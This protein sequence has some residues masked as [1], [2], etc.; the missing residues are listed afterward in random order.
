MKMSGF[1]LPTVLIILLL[2]STINPKGIRGGEFTVN[3][4]KS[5]KAIVALDIVQGHIREVAEPPKWFL[6]MRAFSWLEVGIFF[7]ISGYGLTYAFH[8]NPDFITSF[9]KRIIKVLVPFLVAHIVYI[10]GFWLF[11]IPFA[12]S[13]IVYSL[14]GKGTLVRNGWYVPICL[15][16]YLIFWLIWSAVNGA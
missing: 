16:Y 9:S 4:S 8:R 6:M 12:F 14:F 10:V 1:L 15:L 3:Q 2:C 13:D 7:F 11:G 5:L